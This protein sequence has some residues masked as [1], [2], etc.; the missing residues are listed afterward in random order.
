MIGN[1]FRKKYV[2]FLLI[3]A[4][5]TISLGIAIW[6][7]DHYGTNWD[8]PYHYRR[9]QAF[10]HY[11][12]TGKKTY[13]GLPKYP[14]LKGDSDNPNFRN[15]QENF[16][17]VQANPQL[18]S[19]DFRRSFYQD[20]SWNGEYFIDIES[21]YGHP[22][23]NDIF[24]SLFNRIFYQKLNMLGDLES[25][26]FFIIIIVS[27]A[28]FAM[29]VFIWREFGPI[30]SI[31]TSLAFASYPLI[32]AE[33]HFNIKD[34]VETAFYTL[35]IISVYLS[36]RKAKLV[37]L[38]AA[39]IFFGLALSTK[40]NI[41]FSL[42]PLA[43]WLFYF[44]NQKNKNTNKAKLYKNIGLILVIAP[45]LVVAILFASYP[46]LWRD[47]LGGFTQIIKFY[48]NDG[49]SLSQ[50]ESYYFF[51]I[52]NIYPILWITITT[53]PIVLLLVT[54]AAIF[55]RKLV[56]KNSFVLLLFLWITTTIARNSLFG[57]LSYGGVRLIMEYIPA[58]AMLAGIAAGHLIRVGKNKIYSISVALIL[59]AGF[60]PTVV[61]LTQIHPNENIYFNFLIGGLAGAKEKNI[62]SWG[63]SNGNAYYQGIIW[64]NQHAE[65]NAKV[66]V[67]IGNTSNIPRF[68]LRSD[69]AVSPY[70]WSGLKHG[71]EYLIELTSDHPTKDWFALKYLESAMVPVYEIK[72]DGV[73]IAKV[74]KN[75]LSKV[76]AE[77]RDSVTAKT[78]I[79]I[80]TKSKALQIELPKPKRVI[81]IKIIH[82][83]I[84]CQQVR[85]GYTESSLDSK[86][87][88]REP[89]DIAVDQQNR[90]ELKAL[91][92]SF[93]YLFV[94][95]N[96]K[97]IKFNVD[98][99]NSCLLKATEA[100][101]NFLYTP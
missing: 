8:E 73:A 44:L 45:I 16:E 36:I 21:P 100:F 7:L 64:L 65:T 72:V 68:K 15:A 79:Q 66:S 62:P 91:S 85:T 2:Q 98:S 47:P 88:V 76:K 51:E 28:A 34:P 54:S 74:W 33:Q 10:L 99:E 42:I 70:Y 18:A 27:L 78:G 26:R 29:A 81:E 13:E 39:A 93:S 56:G 43:L 23:L 86:N 31:F 69:I 5:P 40:F 84:N 58:T 67:P 48:S 9:G 87:W 55:S 96:A 20:D 12:L 38:L 71:G 50:P 6:S 35:T 89:E 90:Q 60:V 77:F 49:Y 4:I 41:L 95:R 3:L 97:I 30:E 52:F 101:V 94:A 37:W 61:K 25:Y 57:A 92:P 17:K 46:T 14:P 63:N 22:P 53:P 75:D 11:F 1:I 32:L 80:D 24:A 59:L 19:P 83:K 82:P